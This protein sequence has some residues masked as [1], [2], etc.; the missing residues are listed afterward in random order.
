MGL[1]RN[2]TY[3]ILQNLSRKRIINFIPRKNI[4]VI[5]YL[6]DRVDSEELVISK[7]V[8]ED[9]KE[10]FEE[11]IAAMINYIQND[12][13]CRS[14]QL[15]RYFGEDRSTDCACCDVCLSYKGEN[16][17]LKKSLRETILDLL[18]DGKKH[19]ITELKGMDTDASVTNQDTLRATLEELI[20]E[21]YIYMEGSYVY[22]NTKS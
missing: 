14:R 3:H 22:Q 20:A 19:H 18:A 13:T 7:A 12:Y 5:K 16:K 10:K 6:Q 17:Q 8:Y 21:E 9:R 1:D 2:E 15:L 4:P 11:R